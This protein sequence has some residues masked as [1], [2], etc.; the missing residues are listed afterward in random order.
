MTESALPKVTPLEG[1]T[2]IDDKMFF[3]S[4]RLSYIS[5]QSIAKQIACQVKDDVKEKRVVIAGTS[6]LADFTNLQAVYLELESLQK[7]YDALARHGVSLLDRR[8]IEMP[9]KI[10]SLMASPA[11]L[12]GTAVSAE[13]APITTILGASLG[14]ISLFRE[15]VEYH[16]IKT[17]I[18][19]IAFELVVASEVKQNGG[20]NVFVPDLIAIPLADPRPGSLRARIEEVQDAKERAWA[21]AGPLVS[22]LVRMDTELDLAAKSKDQDKLDMLTFESSQFRRDLQPLS[23]SLARSDQRLA[24]LQKQLNEV[25]QTSSLT[26]MARLLRAEGIQSLNP[27]YLHAQVVASGGHHRITRNLFR[28]LFLGDGLSFCGG[29]IVRWA[30]LNNDGSVAKGGIITLS[31]EASS[32]QVVK[33]I[34]KFQ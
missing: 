20:G 17:E 33:E 31:H 11:G 5:A 27:L 28:T 12:V 16:G 19:P 21:V 7:D 30:L 22:E 1:K 10:R 34:N 4:T 18:D 15:D 24:D 29:G 2:T 3:E 14:L 32:S 13:I 6:L 8:K 25:N 9:E 26:Q 23:D